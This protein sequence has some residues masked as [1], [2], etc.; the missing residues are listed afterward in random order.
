[1]LSATSRSR[2]QI[3]E[4]RSSDQFDRARDRQVEFWEFRAMA[5]KGSG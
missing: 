5:R 4:V 3:F 2:H 1:M